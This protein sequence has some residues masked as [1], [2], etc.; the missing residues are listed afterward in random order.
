MTCETAV[1]AFYL[2]EF[3]KLKHQY[4]KYIDETTRRVI[5]H[6]ISNNFRPLEISRGV[7]SSEPTSRRQRIRSHLV[8]PLP[9]PAD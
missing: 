1:Q 2:D 8:D 3:I 9:F 4:A 5:Q 7:S 6:L